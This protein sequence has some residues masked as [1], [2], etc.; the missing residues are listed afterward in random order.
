[1]KMMNCSRK[2]EKCCLNQD[3]LAVLIYRR[4]SEIARKKSVDNIDI[5]CNDGVK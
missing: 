2:C 1:M 4:I 3:T 5:E